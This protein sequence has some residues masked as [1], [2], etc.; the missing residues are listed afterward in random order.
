M[1]TLSQNISSTAD[2]SIALDRIG[3]DG[4]TSE[5]NRKINIALEIYN[6]SQAWLYVF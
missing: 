6:D 3:C 1:R 2:N 4:D 5:L